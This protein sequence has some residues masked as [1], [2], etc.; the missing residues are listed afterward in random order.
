MLWCACFNYDPEKCKKIC[1]HAFSGC[2]SLASVSLPDGLE[3]IEKCAFNGCNLKTIVI[4]ETVKKVGDGAF[5]YNS[6][7]DEVIIKNPMT[8]VGKR[9]F[10]DY[11]KKRGLCPECGGE[12]KKKSLFSNEMVCSRCNKK[13]C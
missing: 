11:W 5:G 12:P 9:C 4:P 7:L 6:E 8:V 13:I 2:H 3:E 1:E 10:S